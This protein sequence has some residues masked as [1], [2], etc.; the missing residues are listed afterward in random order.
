MWCCV[1]R[2]RSVRRGGEA[3]A[4]VLP[5]RGVRARPVSAG[6]RLHPDVL[7]QRR[8]KSPRARVHSPVHLL[9][10]MAEL[11]VKEAH[12]CEQLPVHCVIVHSHF[13]QLFLL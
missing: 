8:S 12:L 11:Q 9:V 2:R 4:D 6:A 5:V 10:L 3:A 13:R 1:S 7:P